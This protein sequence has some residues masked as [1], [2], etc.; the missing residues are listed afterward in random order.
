MVAILSRP[1]CV[2]HYYPVIAEGRSEDRLTIVHDV[3]IQMYRKPHTKIY[4][5]KMH[6]FQWNSKVP[7]EISHKN[8]TLYTA[9]NILRD[10]KSWTNGDIFE[11]WHLRVISR[12]T[13]G[14][15]VWYRLNQ[16][17][18]CMLLCT[19]LLCYTTGSIHVPVWVVCYTQGKW[20]HERRV[21]ITI[22]V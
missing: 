8:F 22:H 18:W 4:I 3:T 21:Y 2:N 16:W 14:D 19:Q 13:P 11:L 17:G 5:N 20:I 7:F 15:F 1:Q 6:I 12:R 9:K 10:V